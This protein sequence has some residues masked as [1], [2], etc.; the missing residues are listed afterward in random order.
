MSGFGGGFGSGFGQNTNTQSTGFGGGFGATNTNTG[1]SHFFYTP[2]VN[3][4]METK[5][6]M[7]LEP[8]RTSGSH[9]PSLFRTGFGATTNNAGFGSTANTSGGL[10]GNSGGFGSSGGMSTLLKRSGRS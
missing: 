1:M 5:T 7:G 3:H 6:R 10:F 4:V 9:G 2:S 8:A